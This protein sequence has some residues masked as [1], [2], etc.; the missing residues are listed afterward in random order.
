MKRVIQL[1]TVLIF[2]L[3]L[4]A[5]ALQMPLK[6]VPEPTLLEKRALASRPHLKSIREVASDDFLNGFTAYVNDNFGFRKIFIRLNNLIDLKVLKTPSNQD[7]ILGAE[8]MLFSRSADWNGV[9]KKHTNYT[10]AQIAAGAKRVRDFQDR[11]RS[12]GKEFLFVFAPNKATI[13]PELLI[14]HK[15]LLNPL[16]ERERWLMAL[17]SAGVN[18]LDV[19]PMILDAKQKRLLYYNGDHHWNRFASLMASQLIVDTFA[20]RMNVPAPRF[21]ITG[22]RP[23]GW[24]RA[25]GGSYDEMLGVKATRVNEEPIVKVSG[26]KLPR[27]VVFGDSFLHWLYLD[28]ASENFESVADLSE[29]EKFAMA[30]NRA[31][32]KF[33]LV[34]MWEANS[35]KLIDNKVWDIG[36]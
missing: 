22:V 1:G 20:S 13:Y 31:D 16:S 23:D 15:Y 29:V 28:Q 17:K 18:S 30:I 6:I 12:H 24:E 19:A 25:G 3:L 4:L 5:V 34:H 10:D 9:I 14:A 32:T 11:L 27:G 36:K 33:V 8:S 35:N 7:I 2:F 26:N 21:E